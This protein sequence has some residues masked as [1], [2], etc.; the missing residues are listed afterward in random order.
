MKRRDLFKAGVAAIA[1]P[2]L[3]KFSFGK[4]VFI[5]KPG[6]KLEK[7]PYADG[8]ELSIIGFGGIVVVGM[9]QNEANSTVSESIDYGVNYFDVAPSYWDGEAEEKLGAALQPYRNN[10][11]LACKTE[12][13]DAQGAEKE[14]DISLKRVGVEHFDLYQLHAVTEM[15]EVEKI[16]APGG[17]M[18]AFVKAQKAG[19]IRFIGFSA[20]SEE[21]ALALLDRFD[22]NSVLFPINFVSYAQGNFGPRV[23]EKAKE[24]GA[25]RL[26]LK[27]LAHTPI[28]D[29]E[30]KEYPKCWYKP[31][32]EKT[33]AEKALRFTLSQDITAAIPPGDERLYKMAL[34]LAIR[35]EPMEDEEINSLI[36]QTKNTEPLFPL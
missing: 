19:K 17:A 1:T 7:R 23:V 4:E 3:N 21:A 28:P 6:Q 26:A 33:L 2:F 10:I 27:A 18:E 14:L 5:N 9:D 32:D 20:H 16:F 25:S 31:V 22:F 24:K 29:D 8:V 13:R 35:Y 36:Q 15:G 34:E 12:E 11:F 30:E